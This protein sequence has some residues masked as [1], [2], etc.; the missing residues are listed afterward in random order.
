M[1]DIYDAKCEMCGC[2][3]NVHIGDYCVPREKIRLWCPGPLCQGAAKVAER[4]ALDALKNFTM[5]KF[6]SL[7]CTFLV[8]DPNAF[9]IFLND[10]VD[11]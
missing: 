9:A 7:G 11:D 3:I 6:A 5:K 2:V 4:D 10:D 8:D 1:C